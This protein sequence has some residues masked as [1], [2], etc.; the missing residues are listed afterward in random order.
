MTPR[1]RYPD[2]D[3]D[4][5]GEEDADFDSETDAELDCDLLGLDEA[6]LLALT[7]GDAEAD[8]LGSKNAVPSDSW[9]IIQDPPM[10]T[11]VTVS[12]IAPPH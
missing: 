11:S 8:L 1:L 4:T 12:P 7:D 10:A 5:D 3:A 2:A 6:D 9:T